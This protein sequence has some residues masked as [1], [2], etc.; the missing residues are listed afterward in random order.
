VQTY[1]ER[2]TLVYRIKIDIEN[3]NHE[4]KLGMPADGHIKLSAV[5]TAATQQQGTA[6]EK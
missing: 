4:L 5:N 3:P 1:K 6:S 2:V